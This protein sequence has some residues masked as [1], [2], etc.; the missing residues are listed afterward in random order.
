MKNN[1]R[2]L[3]SALITLASLGLAPLAYAEKT[4]IDV[5]V[6]Y[7]PGV[8]ST[9]SGNPTTRINQLFAFAN[10]IYADSGVNLEIHLV[11][12]VEVNYP[13]TGT[14]N[15]ALAAIKDGTSTLSTIAALRDQSKA[16]M[17]IFYRKYDA[18]HNYCGLAY[19]GGYGS[20]TGDV[21]NYKSLMFGT[22]SI[23]TCPDYV[24]THELG[25]NMGLRHSR[26]Q[27]TTGGAFPYALGYGV[28]GQFT[29]VMAYES[30]FGD[31]YGTKKAY[32]FSNPLLTCTGVPCGISRTDS[33][34]G[35][36]AAYALNITT[37]Q[38]AKF[39]AGSVTPAGKTAL[40]LLDEKVQSAKAASDKA[41]AALTANTTAITAKVAIQAS[42]TAA[43]TAATTAAKTAKLKYEA[44]IKTYSDSANNVTLLTTKR[45]AALAAYNTRS[46]DSQRITNFNIYNDVNASYTAAVTKKTKDLAASEL[47]R[48]AFQAAT[49]SLASATTALNTAT[50]NVTAEKSLTAS[51]T[52][53]LAS[54]KAA[55]NTA[56]AAY[57]TGMKKTASGK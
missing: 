52:A 16:D 10:K 32:K 8:T 45:A 19:I 14:D 20:T 7:T 41:L 33:N 23:N 38:I 35:S 57:N 44:S 37:P 22:M 13:D 47:L 27:D 4:V 56:L 1:I 43:L 42:A 11:K 2:H 54:T 34:N 46:S 55:Y 40:E 29:T 24:T 15:M 28:D 9:Y 49:K 26:K 18:S 6:V 21:S 31:A 5:M 53:T 3:S 36:D 48:V 17:V 51:L 50:T 12:A 30:V 25:H 39:Y